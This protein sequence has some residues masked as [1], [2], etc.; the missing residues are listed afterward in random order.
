MGETGF[1]LMTGGVLTSGVAASYSE[2]NEALSA[3]FFNADR[4]GQLVY[5]DHDDR[6]FA[7]ACEA[8]GLQ[9]NAE[10]VESLAAAVRSKLCWRES[11][12][13]SFAE[14]DMMTK[15][16]VFGRRAAVK[17]KR[18]VLAPP[19]IAL[20][21]LLSI[22]A[23]SM[24]ALS[25][26]GEQH[27]GSYYTQLERI[28]RIPAGEGPRLRISFMESSEA[29]WE[30]LS[31]W[32]ED[33]VGDRG[34]PSAYAL[35][36]RYVGLPI[37][38]ALIRDTERR[39]LEKFFD[40]QGFVSGAAVSHAEMH[41]SLDI[42]LHASGGSANQALRKIWAVSGNQDRVTELALA[43][44]SAWDGPV[45]RAS[46]GRTSNRGTRCL[47]TWRSER[48]FLTSISKFGLVVMQGIQNGGSGTVEAEDGSQLEVSFRPAGNNT[49]GVSFGDHEVDPQSMVGAEI[50]ITTSDKQV[51][52]RVPRNV[53]IFAHDSMTASYVE[54]DRALAGTE[55]RILVKDTHALASSV[56]R[57]LDDAAQPGFSKIVGGFKDGIPPGWIAYVDVTFLRSPADELLISPELSAFQ[58]RMTT[59]M[60]LQGGLRLPGRTRRWSA[61][62]PLT[63]VIT[64][65][66]NSK[67]DLFRVDRNPDSLRATEV[68]VQSDLQPPVE[69]RVD[70]L[71]NGQTDFTLSL[72][73]KLS[74][75]QNLSIKLRG[76]DEGEPNTIAEPRALA[77]AVG[78]PLWPLKSIEHSDIAI[79]WIA[80]TTVDV[81]PFDD[82]SNSAP[83]PIRVQ[84]SGPNRVAQSRKKL[85][86]PGPAE[87]SCIITGAHVFVF[88]SFDGKYP[89]TAWMYGECRGCGMSKRQPTRIKNAQKHELQVAVSPQRAALPQPVVKA[90]GPDLSAFLDALI[91]LGC[92]TRRD[93]S[94]LARQLEDSALFERQ[95]LMSLESIAFLEVERDGNLDVVAWE[96]VYQGIAGLDNGDWL[97]AGPWTESE[98]EE[99]RESVV[100]VGGKFR[101]TDAETRS[102]SFIEGIG[103][104]TMPIV[105]KAHVDSEVITPH[106]AHKLAAALPPLSQIVAEL[107]RA[108][109][110]M[111]ATYEYFNVGN[112]TW[113]EIEIAGLP[114]LYRLPRVHGAGYYLRTVE[115]IESGTGARVWA[116]LGKHLAANI[117]GRL[118]I[119]YDPLTKNL[120]VPL[121]AEL[122]GLYGRV[123]VTAAGQ[124]PTA[125]PHFH[126]MTYEGLSPETVSILSR[127]LTS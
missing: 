48:K 106:A 31:V 53:A 83:I 114:G 90:T 88:P 24:G 3:A 123:A 79:G 40:E 68:L 84:W 41:A 11:H 121:G 4:A 67:V 71:R 22:A 72:R 14:F 10:A 100:D 9:P 87:N 104:E 33:N 117:L 28:L 110:P 74:T 29:Y 89:K 103:P 65:D 96:S 64:T 81:E 7:S 54:V 98:K 75:L 39:N 52:R 38:Q 45:G 124:L 92:G 2:W 125:E 109:F 6:G 99:L 62:A 5:L 97:L 12:R 107:P 111:A 108:P 60:S 70:D 94:V 119:A 13:A 37:S 18:E 35:M 15:R 55:T 1:G 27:A 101:V 25:A 34:L 46:G 73:R 26:K 86:L 127:K 122:P 69:L 85:R 8:L 112:A 113:A 76:A 116:E 120:R 66:D 77:H 23:E 102:F 19:N 78:E 126:S 36:H 21:M 16:W 93:F 91:Y 17:A 58:P 118:L 30:A 49:F 32:L 63:L 95:L 82:D 50:R 43:E 57:I 59:Q 61:Y 20:L 44:F 47:L 56:E 51:L 115:D 105:A 42:W 80:G